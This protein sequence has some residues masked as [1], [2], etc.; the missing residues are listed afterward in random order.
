MTTWEL[1]EIWLFVNLL[2]L[3]TGV[4]LLLF[5]FGIYLTISNRRPERRGRP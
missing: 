2:D 5:A 4:V 3:L 1:I